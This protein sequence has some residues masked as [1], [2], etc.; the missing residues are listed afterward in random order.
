[1]T[2]PQIISAE[3]KQKP[4]KNEIIENLKKR[5]KQITTA[6]IQKK[7]ENKYQIEKPLED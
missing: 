2:L 3:F 7:L 1:M 6:L 5:I 4:I